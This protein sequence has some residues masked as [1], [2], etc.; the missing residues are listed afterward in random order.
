ME[1]STDTLRG[2]ARDGEAKA[3]FSLSSASGP[4]RHDSWHQA[5]KRR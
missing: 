1:R 5:V 3:R 2:A 4:R